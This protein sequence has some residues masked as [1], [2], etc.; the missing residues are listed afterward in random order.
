MVVERPVGVDTIHRFVVNEVVTSFGCVV[1]LVVDSSLVVMVLLGDLEVN[2]VGVDAEVENVDVGAE[3][4]NVGDIAE[5]ENTGDVSIF[6]N[7]TGNCVTADD[8]V[9]PKNID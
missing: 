5:V 9:N 3:V 4:E 1:N 8:G 7:D 2:D 6:D